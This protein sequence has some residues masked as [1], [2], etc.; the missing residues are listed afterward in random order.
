VPL[1]QLLGDV[2]QL[3]VLDVDAGAG[4]GGVRDDR[5]N[6]DGAVNRRAVTPAVPAPTAPR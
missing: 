2:A 6:V 1:V 3:L 4:G 5:R